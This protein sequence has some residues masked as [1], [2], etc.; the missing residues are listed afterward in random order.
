MIR[1][2]TIAGIFT[3]SLF[4]ALFLLA[5]QQ[6]AAQFYGKTFDSVAAPQ[7]YRT[8]TVN[9]AAL[10]YGTGQGI[11]YAMGFDEDGISDDYDF[12]L[13]LRHVAYQLH[14]TAERQ[15]HSLSLSF[16]LL[17]NLYFGSTLYTRTWEAASSNYTLGGLLRPIDF[18]SI[19]TTVDFFEDGSTSYRAGLGLRPLALVSKGAAPKLNITADFPFT[20]DSLQAPVFGL[21][22]EPLEGVEVRFGYDGESEGV[23]FEVGLSLTNIKTGFGAEE[24]ADAQVTAG[25][26]Y[27][28]LSPKPFNRF[29]TPGK[30]LIYDFSVGGPIVESKRVVRFGGFTMLSDEPTVYE[31]CRRIRKLA[32]DPLISGIVF[33]NEHP[34]ENLSHVLELKA[35]LDDFRAAGKRVVFFSEAMSSAE[36]LLAASSA[37]AVYLSPTGII[38]LKGASISSPYLGAFLE[39]WGVEV[40]NFRSGPYKSAYDFLSESQMRPEEREQLKS[41]VTDIHASMADLIEDGRGDLI[42]EAAARLI[43]EG[44]YLRAERALE[45]GLVDALIFRDELEGTVPFFE[46]A[47]LDA[48][49][50]EDS[51]RRDWH[52]PAAG[53]IAVIHAAGPIHSGEGLPGQSIG[54][55]GLSR[56]IR[57]ARENSSVKAIL[58]RIDSG[59]GSAIA[60]ASIA[61]EVKLCTEGEEAK[62]IVVSMGNSAASGG[63]YIAAYADVIVAQP[64]TLTGSIGVVAPIPNIESFF[65]QQ[66]IRWETVKSA[67]RADFG[68]LSRPLTAEEEELMQSHIE[69]AYERFVS[70]V[71]EGREMEKAEVE[72]LA[73]GRVWTGR[74]AVEKGLADRLGGFEEALSAAREL[75][76]LPDDIELV[77]FTFADKPWGIFTIDRFSPRS[78]KAE[79]RIGPFQIDGPLGDYLF[80][81]T[82]GETGQA[83]YLMP[84]YIPD[85]G[86]SIGDSRQGNKPLQ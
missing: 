35:A 73:G 1:R 46:E 4:A 80:L 25:R 3:A 14:E 56:T 21:L 16:P 38:D 48:S 62:P 37:D 11:G 44:P 71:A 49:I 30:D 68:G 79:T 22:A 34:T 28:H 81:R 58:L 15:Y 12:F 53:K 20:E 27:V 61:R 75:A 41:L 69:S 19:G 51:V 2:I 39:K 5:P 63:Y 66:L 36:Y 55:E 67:E 72:K 17:E 50:A 74:Q 26:S 86:L 29:K 85:E 54:S 31:V 32:E 83:L 45:A 23:F 6:A 52:L 43:D 84:Y 47:Y 70:V 33:I 24:D 77:D 18:L 42:E 10:S 8:V 40:Q 64:T 76:D 9:P 7:S 57:R 65:E 82:R 13:N 60:S 59:G 78:V